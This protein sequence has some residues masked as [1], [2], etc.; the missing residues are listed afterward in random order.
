MRNSIPGLCFHPSNQ[1]PSYQRQAPRGSTGTVVLQ[2]SLAVRHPL[3]LSKQLIQYTSLVCQPLVRSK[4]LFCSASPRELPLLFPLLLPSADRPACSFPSCGDLSQRDCAARM[5]GG[6]FS[7]GDAEASSMLT[8]LPAGARWLQHCAGRHAVPRFRE[9]P[10]I[11]DTGPVLFTKS[12]NVLFLL[13]TLCSLH[14]YRCDS[15]LRTFS[16]TGDFSSCACVGW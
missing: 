11:A 5:R 14:H 4:G 15:A 10:A 9:L 7:S 2:S 16:L 3:P 6:G 1:V 12:Y 8:D 13:F